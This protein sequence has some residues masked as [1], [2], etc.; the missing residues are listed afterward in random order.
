MKYEEAVNGKISS[1]RRWELRGRDLGVRRLPLVQELHAFSDP[2]RG[3]LALQ[4]VPE[5]LHDP[6]VI[7]D[8]VR[9]LTEP[10]ILPAVHEQHDVLLRAT[11]LVVQ[12]DA[13]MPE[14]G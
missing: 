6:V 8:L 14:H 7:I 4:V 1:F 13:L 10:V 3:R 12:L 9:L 5:P 11:R 2:R